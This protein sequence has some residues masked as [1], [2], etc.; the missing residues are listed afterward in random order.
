M[1]MVF[2]KTGTELFGLLFILFCF[3]MPELIFGQKSKFMNSKMAEIAGT[4]SKPGWITFK[5][6][7]NL[8]ADELFTKQKE[9]FRL[10]DDDKMVVYRTDSDTLGFTHSRFYQYYKGVRI[11]QSDFIVHEKNGELKSGN[12]KIVPEINID[13]NPA[14]TETDALAAALKYINAEEYLWTIPDA[15]ALVKRQ[16]KDTNATYYPKGELVLI[17]P[18]ES[19]KVNAET[20]R[21]CWSFDIYTHKPGDANRV[22]IDAKTGTVFRTV[23]LSMAC[24]PDVATGNTTWHG[25]GYSFRVSKS[26]S[27]Y[28]MKDDCNTPVWWVRDWNGGTITEYNDLDNTWTAAS[29]QAQVQSMWGIEKIY[30]YYKSKFDRDSYDNSNA[31]IVAVNEATVFG[32]VN[33][34]CWGCDG[35]VMSL[36]PGST[37]AAGDDWNTIDI[38]GH[39][40]THGVVW[41]TANLAYNKESGA[42][43]E[44]FSDIFG[45][46][47]E[48][49]AEGYTNNDWTLNEDRGSII[50]SFSSPGTYNDPDTYEGTNWYNIVGCVPA[51]ANDYCGV[52]TNSGVQNK[53]FFLLTDGENGTNDNGDDYSVSGIGIFKSEQIAYRNL[54][55][56]LTSG[57]N[58]HDSRE[59]SL[60]AAK[61]LYGNCSNEA[62][63]T[64]EAWY[65]VGVGV[66]ETYYDE[67]I[68]GV[69][70]TGTYE[71]ISTIT[72]GGVSTTVNSGSTVTIQ[73]AKAAHLTPP[74]SAASGSNTTVKINSCSIAKESVAPAP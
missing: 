21:L 18:P 49:Y 51:Q 7:L 43:N 61:D 56:Y 20:L 64:G 59:G 62:I 70:P 41:K 31:D 44:S 67:T 65:A 55:Y 57:S 13:V 68:T 47:V 53:W 11:E 8:T 73:A 40:F 48:R 71:G 39:E 16:N 63:Q 12:G 69:L 15:E 9:A 37:A 33:N 35:A 50:R 1:N 5:P 74:F 17:N 27:N 58:Y 66:D 28:F 26:G 60:Q 52:H 36:G 4:A 46:C 2:K 72:A 30:W 54:A 25:N 38:E 19:D 22:F 32:T 29:Q 6:G 14:F 23:A 3:F 45:A 42:L 34:S 10:S 24:D